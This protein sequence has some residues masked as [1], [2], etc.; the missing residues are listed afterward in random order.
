MSLVLALAGCAGPRFD[1][2]E[3]P[4]G[5]TAEQRD[6]DAAQCA[7]KHHVYGPWV[8]GVGS[9]ILYSLRESGYRDCM[10]TLGYV[11]EARD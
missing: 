3:A 8:L 7:R 6:L 10:T 4:A 5:K 9:A 1:I 2:T 11:V